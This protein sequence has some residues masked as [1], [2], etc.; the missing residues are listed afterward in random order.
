VTKIVTRKAVPSASLDD[1]G[2]RVGKQKK[3]ELYDE[4]AGNRLPEE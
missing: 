4:Y 2:G 3:K 1:L